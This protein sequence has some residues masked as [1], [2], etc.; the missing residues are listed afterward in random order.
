MRYFPAQCGR[1]P[2]A[3]FCDTFRIEK[4]NG[5]AGYALTTGRTAAIGPGVPT[6]RAVSWR[7]IWPG[8]SAQPPDAAQVADEVARY[9]VLREFRARLY[10]CLTARA[11]ACFELVD[12]V[13]CADHAVTSLVQLS[14][15]PQFRRGPGTARSMT[16]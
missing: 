14:L 16:R 3:G 13:L 9:R 11:D 8:T 1:F 6:A 4:G 12:A 5:R 10:G 15:V 2:H 7:R